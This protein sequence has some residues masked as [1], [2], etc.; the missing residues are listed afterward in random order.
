M[1]IAFTLSESLVTQLR[2]AAKDTGVT[3]STLVER[4]LT[5]GLAAGI[6][7]RAVGRPAT[8]QA[9]NSTLSQ[10]Q[11]TYTQPQHGDATPANTFTFTPF[12]LTDEE[13]AEFDV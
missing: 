13:K 5:D 6:T 11:P 9:S 7:L 12:E 1:R 8:A 4:C 10:P 2:T 3:M